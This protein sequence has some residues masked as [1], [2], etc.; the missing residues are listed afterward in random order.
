MLDRASRYMV[1]DFLDYLVDHPR[2][3]E[4]TKKNIDCFNVAYEIG[5]EISLLNVDDG[6][7]ENTCKI[8]SIFKKHTKIKSFNYLWHYRDQPIESP[9]EIFNNFT[10]KLMY[11]NKDKKQ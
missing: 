6:F 10:I 11:Y 5:K 2:L 7:A 4:D 8:A 9:L 1:I 3:D